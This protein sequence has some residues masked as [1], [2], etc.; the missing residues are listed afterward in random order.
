M[1]CY[2]QIYSNIVFLLFGDSSLLSDMSKYIPT[3]CS[4]LLA[5]QVYFLT[6]P[7]IFQLSVLTFWQCPTSNPQDPVP[8][9]IWGPAQNTRFE[10][11]YL[12]MPL[13]NYSL[14]R[15]ELEICWW[16]IEEEKNSF[17]PYLG[18]IP[19]SMSSRYRCIQNKTG[20]QSLITFMW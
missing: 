4:Y 12:S 19:P 18:T 10:H 8:R 3:S 6:C 17:E 13:W 16:N 11:I 7:N 9:C 2:V 20:L 14:K 1:N 15:W 5:I